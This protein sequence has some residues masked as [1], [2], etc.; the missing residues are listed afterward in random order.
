[1]TEVSEIFLVTIR[2]FIGFFGLLII[3]RLMRKKQLSQYTF[4]DYAVGITIGSIAATLSIEL[5]NRTVTV[6][7][8]LLVWGILPVFLGWLYLKSVTIRKVLDGEA[9]VLIKNGKILEENM[10]RE[11]LNLEDLQMQLR[12]VGVFELADVE[13]AVLE[14]NGQINALK[15]REKQ[16]L[17]PEDIN[18]PVMGKGAPLVLVM[19]GRLMK[20]T[21]KS[22]PFSEAWLLGKLQK[23]GIHDISQVILAQVD[24]TGSLYLDI[25][26][27]KVSAPPVT[28]E[29]KI[30]ANMDK[31]IVELESLLQK[32]SNPKVNE[33]YIQHRDRLQ[34][35]S[36]ELK[37]LL[38]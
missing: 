25:E 4:Y 9:I 6:F 20:D 1:M 38:K 18:L 14:K 7:W 10:K 30:L 23:K 36:Q 12:S 33:M 32:N 2:S 26:R 8:G 11:L 5:E 28:E 29:D 3:M 37:S 35:I 17:T 27:D 19:D 16:P 24:T 31:I 21:I 15:K 22:S 34:Q 13:Y